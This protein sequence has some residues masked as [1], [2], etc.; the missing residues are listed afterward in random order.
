MLSNAQGHQPLVAKL[1][2]DGCDLCLS[3]YSLSAVNRARRELT[4]EY[5]N[6]P[7]DPTLR[8]FTDRSNFVL[9]FLLSR[10]VE[11]GDVRPGFAP[12]AW[13]AGL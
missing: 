9:C 11:V 10:S 12:L 7:S 13:H 3:V 6:P 1:G 8:G 4:C 2:G 5:G